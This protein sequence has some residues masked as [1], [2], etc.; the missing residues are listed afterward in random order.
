MVNADPVDEFSGQAER[1]W[2]E[3]TGLLRGDASKCTI[4]AEA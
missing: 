1:F 2:Y 4:R 3:G